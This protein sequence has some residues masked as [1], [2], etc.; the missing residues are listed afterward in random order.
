MATV[1]DALVVTL[2][3]DLAGMKK[4]AKEANSTLESLADAAQ[5]VFTIMGGVALLRQTVMT[6]L[7]NADA[8]GKLTRALG[9]DVEMVQVWSNAAERAGGSAEAMQGT[10]KTLSEE[11]AKLKTYGMS[12]TLGA[13]QWFGVEMRNAN[14]QIKSVDEM[15]LT[16]SERMEGMSSMRQ[17]TIGQRLGLDEGTVVLLQKGRKELEALLARQKEIGVY[18]KQDVE[19][20]RKTKAA[21]A[22]LKQAWDMAAGV[23][24]RYLAPALEWIGQKLADV[25][26]WARQH[27]EF[28]ISLFTAI[29]GIITVVL[30]PV[31]EKMALKWLAAFAPCWAAIAIIAAL[32]A[33]IALLYDDY[34]AWTEG[35]D[36]LFGEAW[37]S[38]ETF[39]NLTMDAFKQL[40]ALL[41]IFWKFIKPLA[42]KQLLALLDIVTGVF[43]GIAGL[44]EWLAGVF[45][46]D[47]DAMSEGGM[48]VLEG[49]GNIA[50]G[51]FLGMVQPI[52][53]VANLLKDS[54]GAA[55]DW[56]LNKFAAL[57][58]K[59][60]A[61]KAMIGMGGDSEGPAGAATASAAQSA[62]PATIAGAVTNAKSIQAS[63]KIDKIEVHTAATDARGIAGDIGGALDSQQLALGVG[64]G[65]W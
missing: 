7:D 27:K 5:K 45:T 8:V 3:L 44:L 26:I 39:V 29:A 13:W 16:L 36:S 46:G 1:V 21:W 4:G 61:F 22:D 41:A 20:A 62:S 34:A 2:G 17:V 30:Y 28:M 63:T 65:S 50:K 54:L 10:I 15:L 42:G 57:G 9:L 11:L 56:V 38:V 47:F 25:A 12:A 14:G 35:G 52:L 33:V 6:Y 31:L 32:G 49:F 43:Q 19:S 51:V 64:G 48:K 18:S 58:E 55:V 53:F 60:N 37:G 24:M 40:G 23:V 59:W